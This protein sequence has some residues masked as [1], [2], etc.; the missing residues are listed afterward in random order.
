M[1]T[2]HAHMKDGCSE[3]G[4][5]LEYRMVEI[6]TG[7]SFTQ[8]WLTVKIGNGCGDELDYVRPATSSSRGYDSGL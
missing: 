6:C 4:V 2:S 1:G 7:T 5:L 3:A 8:L